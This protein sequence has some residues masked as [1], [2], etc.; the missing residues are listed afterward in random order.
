MKNERKTFTEEE[1]A[2]NEPPVTGND[3]LEEIR[4]LLDDYFIGEIFFD[5]N[6]VT[7]RLPNGQKFR[8]KA[9]TVA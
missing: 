9:E 7:Y 2:K 8:I 3:L 5:G 1:L 4:P 6:T